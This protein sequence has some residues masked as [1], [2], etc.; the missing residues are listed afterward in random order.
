MKKIYYISILNI[1]SILFLNGCSINNQNTIYKLENSKQDKLIKNIKIIKSDN[2]FKT[3]I[4][5]KDQLKFLCYKGDS[6]TCNYYDY[7]KHSHNGQ[8]PEEEVFWINEKGYYP[9]ISTNTNNIQCGAGTMLGWLTILPLGSKKT[10]FTN[11]NDINSHICNYRFSKVD[12]TQM[13]ERT[14]VGMLTFMTPYL[15]AGNMHTRMFDKSTFVESIHNSNIESFK[16]QLFDMMSEYEIKGGLDVI[17]LEQDNIKD[18]LGNKYKQLLKDNSLKAGII[19]LKYGT[20]KLIDITIFDK[21]KDKDMIS[22]IS[23]AISDLLNNIAQDN[24]HKVKY[25]E[26]LS[27]IP[28]EIDLPKLPAVKIVIKDEF[29]KQTEFEQRI[30][31]E[32]IKRESE[33][34]QLQR[35]YSIDVL[36]R[37]NYIKNLQKQY[38]TYQD[39]IVFNKNKLLNELTQNIP[40]LSKV[41]FLENISGYDANNFNYDS[42]NEKIYF[43]IYSMNQKFYQKVVANIP[44]SSAKKIKQNRT[45]KIIPNIQFKNNKIEL[46]SF[47]ILETSQNNYFEAKYT[48]VNYKPKSSK[49]T[50]LNVDKVLKEDISIQFKRY[51]QKE[52]TVVDI[53]KKEVWYIDIVKRTNAKVPKWFITPYNT[54]DIIGYG[55]GDT[56]EEA[57]ANARK[58]LVQMIQ[59]NVNT[60]SLNIKEIN[61]FKKFHSVKQKIEQSTNIELNSEDY[62]LYKQEKLDG[63]WYVGFILTNSI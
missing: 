29:E 14:V 40:L 58:D 11:Y 49:V 50:V 56:I 34:R 41:L 33:I 45:F 31:K 63:R 35:K 28:K 30:K 46:S 6:K 32:V 48:N 27:L 1:T 43:N 62:T 13:S 4:N 26:I 22:S 15:T 51:K 2:K 8:V 44:A 47:K 10:N 19:F 52:K 25:D 55:D 12:S 23:Y 7:K 42:Q 3:Y 9:N 53:A 20:N 59:V 37:N 61:N 24:Q 54:K 38:I 5:K 16:K 60:V 17:Y 18:N 21:Y 39:E 57:K 36:K